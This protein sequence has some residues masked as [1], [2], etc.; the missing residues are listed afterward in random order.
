MKRKIIKQGHNTL[1][2]T[3]PTQ[4]AKKLNIN[5]GDEIDVLE[6]DN[7]LVIN[8]SGNLQDKC[9]V[10]DIRDFNV[11]LLWRYF[12]GAYRAGCTEIKVL[13]DPKKDKYQDAFHF[14]TT[15][16]EYS[17]FGLK[18]PS[19]SAQ[20]ML[21]EI[22]SRFIGIEI[23][24]N[25]KDYL[26]IKEL[27]E[28]TAKEFDNSL[29]RIFLVILELFDRLIEAIDKNETNDSSLCKEL[30]SIDLNTD[31]FVDYCARIL[32]RSAFDIPEK[33]KQL[34]FSTLFLLELLGDNFKD[35]GKHLALAKRP[36]K[37]A[38]ESS[39]NTKEHFERYYKLYYKYSRDDAIKFFESDVN[40]YTINSAKKENV[41]SKDAKSI[42][43]HL[44]EIKRLTLALAELRIQMEF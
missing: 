11:P 13:F 12:Q 32:N 27:G 30:H 6:R 23:I 37:E 41:S 34:L 9:A 44:L 15:L 3:I 36:V 7:Q 1:T 38:L 10:I 28:P 26:V 35:M 25:S 39:L 31:K 42:I 29:R 18:V 40:V 5:P 24:E 33:K 43:R 4:W 21:Q 2:L 20:V 16:F 8:S 17:E 22:V 19:K 14:Y